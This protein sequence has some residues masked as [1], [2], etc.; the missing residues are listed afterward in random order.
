[1]SRS[2]DTKIPATGHRI[3]WETN[4]VP[5]S[6][7]FD[8][9]FYTR[10]N[11]QAETAYV[12]INGNGLPERWAG[13]AQFSIGELGFGTGLNFLETW[14]HWIAARS[15]S[16]QLVFTSFEAYPINANDMARALAPWT[17]L[18]PLSDALV[19]RW[20]DLSVQPAQW[21]MDRQ[22]TLQV[23]PGKAAGSVAHW[24]GRADAWYLDGFSPSRNPQMWEPDLM[25]QVYEHTN[26]DGSFATYTAAAQVRRTLQAAGFTV[27]KRKGF[28]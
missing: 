16:Q 25:Q 26:P 7:V 11:G 15:P 2:H 23:I 6:S 12:F 28:A 10:D 24:R 21:Q 9:T 18:K 17:N 20:Q 13:A 3:C 19:A 4:D 1:M 5:R 8:D 14:R 22:T 27:S